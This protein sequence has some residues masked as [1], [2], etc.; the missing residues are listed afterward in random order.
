MVCRSSQGSTLSLSMP[1]ESKSLF[2]GVW[3]HEDWLVVPDSDL[4]SE[5]KGSFFGS[6]FFSNRQNFQVA[7]Y[8]PQGVHLRE[9]CEKIILPK[10]GY[11]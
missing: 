11:F 6:V 4:S 5:I 7:K 8:G 3:W 10:H 9:H 1:Y 2:H